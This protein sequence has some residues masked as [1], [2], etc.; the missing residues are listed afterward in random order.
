[1]TKTLVAVAAAAL[2]VPGAAH[3]AAPQFTPLSASVVASP[4]PADGTDGRRH[5]VYE[6]ELRNTQPESVDVLSVAVRGENRSLRRIDPA[7]LST[8]MTVAKRPTGT[9]AAGETG[10]LW[11]DVKAPR[12]TPRILRHRVTLRVNGTSMT[13]DGAATRVDRQASPALEAPLRGGLYLNFNGCCDFSPHRTALLPVDGT[14]HLSERFAV[15]LIRVDAQGRGASGDFTRNESFFTYGRGVYSVAAGRVVHT[16]NDVP[17]NAPLNEPPGSSFT[18][19][20]V[21][22]NHVVVHLNDGRYATYAHLRAGSV[23]VR[24]GDRVR[25]G[26]VLGRVGNSGQS[27]G[28]HLHFQLADGPSPIASN[29]LP[30]TFKRFARVGTVNNIEQFLTGTANADVQPATSSVQRLRQLP[31]QG[32]VL[33]FAR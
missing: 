26:Q 16:L 3:A 24:R 25:A 21:L 28:A 4:A 13:F 5:L 20:T 12:A 9:L 7:E 22:G 29:G 31:L 27:G 33:R 23:R 6:L 8:L 17:D 11:L 19:D 30:F 1:M 2:I 10:T 14:E 32:D 18:T 15:D